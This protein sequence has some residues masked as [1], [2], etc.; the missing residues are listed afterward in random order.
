MAEKNK[1]K[2]ELIERCESCFELGEACKGGTHKKIMTAQADFM[3]YVQEHVKSEITKVTIEASCDMC[4]TARTVPMP[5]FPHGVVQSNLK[6]LTE[7]D[8]K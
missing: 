3:A 6:D 5:G 4:R 2:D 8:V 7:E 1:I